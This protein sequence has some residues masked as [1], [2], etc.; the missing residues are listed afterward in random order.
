MCVKCDAHEMPLMFKD[1]HYMSKA[2]PFV[3]VD[4][5][6]LIRGQSKGEVPVL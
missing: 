5:T 1:L 4:P 6:A 2:L 3:A